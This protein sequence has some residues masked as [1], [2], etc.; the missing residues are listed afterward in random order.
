MGKMVR[1][2]AGIFYKLDPEPHKNGPAPQHWFKTRS[3]SPLMIGR[4][5]I[6]KIIF[7]LYNKSEDR[8]E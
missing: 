5:V 4:F 2:G 1:A 8:I 7:Y 3:K 6:N